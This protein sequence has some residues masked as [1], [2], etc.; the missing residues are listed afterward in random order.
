MK[1]EKLTQQE[2]E[3]VSKVAMKLFDGWKDRP[4]ELTPRQLFIIAFL[5]GREYTLEQIGA[6]DLDDDDMTGARDFKDKYL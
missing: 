3:E 2:M 5:K 6:F 1:I 4:N